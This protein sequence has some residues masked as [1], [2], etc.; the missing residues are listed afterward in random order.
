V[1]RRGTE[2]ARLWSSR[3]LVVT[4]KGGVG[5]STLTAALGRSL[6]ARGRRVL[7]LET[8]PREH[9]HRLLGTAPS[10][11]ERIAAG[12]RL[13]HLNLRPRLVL[14]DLVR[15]RVP[16][17][18]LARAAL[19]SP[20][21]DHFVEGAPGLK[22]MAIL[23]YAYRATETS[24]DEHAVDVVVLDAPATG[25]GAS[26]LAA[27]LLTAGVLPRGPIGE[28]ARELAD[29]VADRERCAVV[30]ATLAEEMPVQEALELIDLLGDRIG[31]RPELVVVN[32]L[33]PPLPSPPPSAPV[34]G[35]A[36]ELWR[37]RRELNER[38]L[39][40]LTARWRGPLATLP[41]LPI[42]SGPAL[43]E[44]LSARLGAALNPRGK[45]A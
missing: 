13:S 17:P 3:L 22:E 38:E 10:G 26:M 24:G 42:D 15:E 6:A 20:V 14:E 32:A 31:R 4:G 8:D 44:A 45:R 23:G 28:L 36:I 2:L 39:A 29:F 19:S 35:G 11:G 1:P 30:V 18:L 37:R 25:H 7:L 40:R 9:L 43:V 34:A 21:F 41:L 27:P 12:E 33:Y 5:K 16:V